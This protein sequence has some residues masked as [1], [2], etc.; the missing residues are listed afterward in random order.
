MRLA[1]LGDVNTVAQTITTVEGMGASF[2][3]PGALRPAGQPGCVPTSTGSGSFCTF[4]DYATGYQALL[5]QINLDAS[6]GLTIQQFMNKY[7]PWQ[8]GNDPASYAATIANATGLSVNDPLSLA[9]T[10]GGYSDPF[11]GFDTSGLGDATGSDDAMTIALAT[12]A[13]LLLAWWL[14]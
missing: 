10:G 13:A 11:G 5:N 2:N 9:L 3:N 12:G 7:A 6:R 8:D 14:G 4:P 1:G